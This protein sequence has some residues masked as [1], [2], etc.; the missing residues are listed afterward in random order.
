MYRIT[1]DQLDFAA[2]FLAEFLKG[3]P[4]SGPFSYIDGLKPARVSIDSADDG[5]ELGCYGIQVRQHPTK[6]GG[7]DG[8]PALQYEVTLSVT[9][10]SASRDEPDTADVDVLGEA[11]DLVG[12]LLLVLGHEVRT[13]TRAMLDGWADDALAEE[14]AAD[15]A[16]PGLTLPPGDDGGYAAHMRSTCP[17]VPLAVDSRTFDLAMDRDAGHAP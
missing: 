11:D 10:T 8:R 17:D 15:M 6:K 14:L 2:R 7:L 3:Q 16:N 13:H 4:S 5:L 9:I 1:D 12:A